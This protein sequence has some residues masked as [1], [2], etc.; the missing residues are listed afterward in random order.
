ME[1]IEGSGH[2]VTPAPGTARTRDGEPA[3]LL[4]GTG[5]PLAASCLECGREIRCDRAGLVRAWYHVPGLRDNE[6]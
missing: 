3:D 4:A 1:L 6:G 5:Y 2:P